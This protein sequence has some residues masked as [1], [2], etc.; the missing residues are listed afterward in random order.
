MSENQGCSE[1]KLSA[2]GARLLTL[3]G[4]RRAAAL[5]A[6]NEEHLETVRFLIREHGVA[7]PARGAVSAE[8]REDGVYLVWSEG[9]P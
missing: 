3:S 5:A 2:V 7:P 8:A 4:E 6:A 1:V 9:A